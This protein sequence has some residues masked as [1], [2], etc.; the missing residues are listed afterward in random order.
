MHESDNNPAADACFIVLTSMEILT[1]KKSANFSPLRMQIKFE[2]L[3]LVLL[4]H[5]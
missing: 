3:K 5:Y 1:A 4:P 2:V